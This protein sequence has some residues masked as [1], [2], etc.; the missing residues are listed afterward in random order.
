MRVFACEDGRDY[1][2]CHICGKSVAR[3]ARFGY[4]LCAMKKIAVFTLLIIV[5]A[6]VGA[7]LVACN[8]ATT[9]GQLVDAW[10][11]ARPYERYTYTV[12][13]SATEGTDGTYVSEIFYHTAYNV[14]VEESSSAYNAEK[15]TVGDATIEQREGYLIRGTLTATLNGKQ[16]DYVTECYFEL[17]DGS[18]YLL[19][20]ATFRS[21]KVDGTE[22]LRMNGA[23]SGSTL[24]YTLVTDGKE[25]VTGTVALSSPYY[26]NNEFHQSLRGVS[27]FS[28][29]F[30]F[31][32]KTAIVNATEQTSASLTFSVSGT[33]NVTLPF[34]SSSLDE[35]GASVSN[36][37]TVLECY[38]AKLSRST[39]V[40]GASQT[41]WY[42][43]NPVYAAIDEDGATTNLCTSDNNWWALPHVLVAFSEPYKS[44]ETSGTVNYV[45]NGISLVRPAAEG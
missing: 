7:T 17:T 10:K 32:F 3:R 30:S 4:N 6:A 15:V 19:P 38:K 5:I 33:E 13:D 2:F 45:L 41:L 37:N 39:T 42:S 29:S 16:V 44:G 12:D 9:Q 23:Y 8:N 1:V 40:S 28:S 11:E 34:P 35:N 36:E 25:A 22:M 31:A 43:V 26:D 24:S 27:T 20:V 18:S 21:E 14:G